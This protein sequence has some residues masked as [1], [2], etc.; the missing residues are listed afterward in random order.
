MKESCSEGLA[1]HA[2]PAPCGAARKGGVEALAGVRAGWVLSRERNSLRGADAVE[3]RG[4]PH[5][6]QRQCKLP[7]NPARSETPRMH[8]NASRE[9]RESRGLSAADGAAERV[10]KSKDKHR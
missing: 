8:G 3:V 6:R 1:N 2:G 4:R 7:E 9:N 10:G 5:P